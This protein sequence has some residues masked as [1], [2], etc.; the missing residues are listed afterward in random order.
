MNAVIAMPF[1]SSV[2]VAIEMGLPGA[3][4]APWPGAAAGRHTLHGDRFLHSEEELTLWLLK[5]E[6]SSPGPQVNGY[7]GSAQLAGIFASVGRSIQERPQLVS[8]AVF[9]GEEVPH[10]A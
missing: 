9:A 4:L 7:R 1:T 6:R 8:S 5:A 3:Y 10:E 2:S